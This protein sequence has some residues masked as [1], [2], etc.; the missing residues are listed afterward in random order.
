MNNEEPQLKR[1]T[2]PYNNRIE[3]TARGRHGACVE[4]L[5]LLF[6]CKP[7][8][9]SPPR[10]GLSPSRSGPCSLLIRALYGRGNNLKDDSWSANAF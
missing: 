10:A 6:A 7:R 4:V 8:A 3:Q 2:S 9:G 1:G 5:G